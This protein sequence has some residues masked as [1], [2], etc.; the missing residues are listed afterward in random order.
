MCWQ[1]AEN[2][3]LQDSN[4]LQP[5]N[6]NALVRCYATRQLQCVSKKMQCFSN[7]LRPASCNVLVLTCAFYRRIKSCCVWLNIKQCTPSST[8]RHSMYTASRQS[9][10][11]YGCNRPKSSRRATALGSLSEN[12]FSDLQ[13]LESGSEKIRQT[14]ISETYSD[15]LIICCDR[16]FW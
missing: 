14:V 11:A 4:K 12:W 13:S 7:K 10:S 9:S 6:S 16:I 15:P 2:N 5:T 8:G 1:G 3:V